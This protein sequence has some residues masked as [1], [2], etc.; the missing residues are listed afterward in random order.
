MIAIGIIEIIEM[1]HQ[2]VMTNQMTRRQ[3]DL[4]HVVALMVVVGDGQMD[5]VV[6]DVV[7]KV[8]IT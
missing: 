8:M 3:K 1:T 4:P 6:V 2:I 5:T 7:D